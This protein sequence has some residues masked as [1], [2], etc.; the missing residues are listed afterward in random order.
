MIVKNES[1]VIARC[2]NSLKRFITHYAIVDTGSTDDT[3]G[4]IKRTLADIPG[5][6]DR[7][8]WV[9]FATNRNQALDLAKASGADFILTLDADEVLEWPDDAPIPEFT[10]DAYGVRFHDPERTATW[11]RTLIFRASMPWKWIGEIHETLDCPG[12][13]PRLTLLA[14]RAKVRSYTDG[15]RGKR[16]ERKFSIYD[17]FPCGR[18][19]RP[20]I[21]YNR[22]IEILESRVK[23]D[24]NDTRAWFYLAQSYAGAERF[25]DALG[26]YQQRATLGGLPEE[27]FMSLL[28]IGGIQEHT[29]KPWEDVAR[30]YLKAYESR[31]VRAEPLWALAVLHNDRNEPAIAEMYARQACRT[32]RP[33]TD[34]LLVNE[35]VYE[36]LAADELAASLGRLGR[37]DECLPIL[38]RIVQ[39]DNL[40][41]TERERAEKNIDYIRSLKE[42]A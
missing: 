21:K 17:H 42:A 10:D 32:P 16:P 8:K 26:A 7:R 13:E 38:E 23:K 31:P 41:S 14:G 18:A 3:V 29:G 1:A 27:V 9:D 6:V 2:L 19:G 28:Q 25:D 36:Y 20:S 11:T 34:T 33:T 35:A 30:S 15:A 37:Y 24:P 12:L 22:D 40:P 4:V 5:V 39:L